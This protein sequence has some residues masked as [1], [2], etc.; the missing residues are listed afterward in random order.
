M[1]APLIGTQTE[2]T[3]GK[4]MKIGKALPKSRFGFNLTSINK[5][6][7]PTST[8]IWD[9]TEHAVKVALRW[10]NEGAVHIFVHS[11]ETHETFRFDADNDDHLEALRVSPVQ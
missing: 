4:I 7:S 2:N 10:F 8:Q 6:G 5:D 11:H 1:V 3:K 9:G